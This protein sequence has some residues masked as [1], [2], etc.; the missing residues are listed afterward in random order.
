[1]VFI[2]RKSR[3]NENPEK[4]KFIKLEHGF[5]KVGHS[6]TAIVSYFSKLPNR[7]PKVLCLYIYKIY[8]PNFISR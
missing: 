4:T 2:D 5:P 7:F 6:L 1:M 8:L 3:F